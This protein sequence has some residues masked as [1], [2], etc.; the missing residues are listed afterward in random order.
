MQADRSL[1]VP[2]SLVIGSAT[3]TVEVNAGTVLLDAAT[4]ELGT[5]VG[6]TQ[7]TNLPMPGR[8][9]YMLANLTPTVKGVGMFGQ[10]IVGSWTEAAVS[11]GGGNALSNGYLIDGL[12]NNKPEKRSSVVQTG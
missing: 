2:V 11:I 3:E 7:I 6:N 10:D 1:V 9:P 5:V 12:S 8:N 4:S